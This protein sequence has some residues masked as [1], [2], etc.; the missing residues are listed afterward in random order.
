MG[1]TPDRQLGD[2]ETQVAT[3]ERIADAVGDPLPGES[4]LTPPSRCTHP[5]QEAKQGPGCNCY[6]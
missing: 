2:V 1:R 5:N 6:R 4:D 3:E